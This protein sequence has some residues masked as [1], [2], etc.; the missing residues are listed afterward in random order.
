MTIAK[1]EPFIGPNNTRYTLEAFDMNVVLK[2]EWGYYHVVS[3]E[4]F[5]QRYKRVAE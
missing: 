4:Q 5:S 2:N 3:Q 1:H